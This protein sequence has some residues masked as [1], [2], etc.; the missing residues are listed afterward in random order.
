MNKVAKEQL[1]LFKPKKLEAVE[2]DLASR[3]YLHYVLSQNEQLKFIE[4][5]KTMM[6][7]GKSGIFDSWSL[8][9]QDMV[10][11]AAHAYGERIV[12]AKIWEKFRR[13]Y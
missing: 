9:N 5:G 6:A 3:D 12:S 11:A 8:Q 13:K 7:A 1:S 10:Q 4:L 2:F